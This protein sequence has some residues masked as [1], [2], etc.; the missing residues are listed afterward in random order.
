[1]LIPVDTATYLYLLFMWAGALLAT[2]QGGGGWRWVC[3]CCVSSCVVSVALF[4][5]MGGATLP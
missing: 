5:L 4:W 3:V 1:M 2:R